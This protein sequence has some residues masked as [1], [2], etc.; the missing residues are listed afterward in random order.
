MRRHT[1]R[2]TSF[3]LGPSGHFMEIVMWM[4]LLWF[5]LFLH[6]RSAF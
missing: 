4:A 5:M 2:E 1:H 3:W 6:A